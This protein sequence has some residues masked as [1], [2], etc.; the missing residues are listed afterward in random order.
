MAQRGKPS[1]AHVYDDR[2]VC[3]HCDM[4]KTNV[5][6]LSHVCKSWREEEVDKKAAKAAKVDLD[7]YRVGGFIKDGK[8]QTI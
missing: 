1:T 2:G 8:W 4:Y 3:I 6:Q 7:T 5:E